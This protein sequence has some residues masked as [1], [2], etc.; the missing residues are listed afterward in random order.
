V[1]DPPKKPAGREVVERVV[2]AAATMVPVAGGP[3]AVAFAAA[4]GW[5]YNRRMDRW[6]DELAAAVSELQERS[7]GLSFDDLA[8]NEDFVDAV[9]AASRAAQATHSDEK[10]DALRNGVL[11]TLSPDAPTLDEQARFFRL[12]E[13]F[14]PAHLRLLSFLND[15]GALFDAA[16]I[17]RPSI[18]MGGRGALLE[19]GLPE[20]KDRGDWYGLLGR[21]L[22]DAGLTS[23]SG[24]NTVQ[25]GASLWQSGTSE[26]GQ[27]FLAFI[28]ESP[29]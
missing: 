23:F 7:N 22:A 1:E 26:L 4:M 9:V 24:L 10:L 15:P 19:G 5:S 11:N 16:E 2:E 12:V 13:Q 25:S 21:D 29:K 14:T 3:L 28:S 6:M 8:D 17:P 18:A 20:F 27:R